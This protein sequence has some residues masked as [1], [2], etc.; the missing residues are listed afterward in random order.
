M[1]KTTL[2]ILLSS[3]MSNVDTS[4]DCWA[5]TGPTN[6]SGYGT[7]QDG[8]PKGVGAHRFSHS[9]FVGNSGSVIRHSCRN[10]ACVKPTHL[11]TGTQS[12]NMQD[13]FL[14][15]TG[16]TQKLTHDDVRAIRRD[17]IRYNQRRSNAHELAEHYGI[18]HKYVAKIAEG[19]ALTY[20]N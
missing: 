19:K 5:W 12:Q 18:G 20:V 4:G 6:G 11:V 7:F 17:F 15:G 13:K 14:D 1:T 2:V 9:I 10:R 3:F 16:N 8:S